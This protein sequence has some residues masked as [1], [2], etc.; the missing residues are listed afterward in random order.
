MDIPGVNV[1]IVGLD[2]YQPNHVEEFDAGQGEP[3]G[4]EE[5]HA[6]RS[7][8]EKVDH[9]GDAV[10][11]P[12]ARRNAEQPW[13]EMELGE[14][15]KVFN[16]KIQNRLKKSTFHQREAERQ[17]QRAAE[18]R[19]QALRRMQELEAA[20]NQYQHAEQ[21]AAA[22][23]S[24]DEIDAQRREKALEL[25][26]LRRMDEFDADYDEKRMVTLDLEL[27]D[28]D[29]AYN[30]MKSA[31]K[32]E[33]K[34]TPR[35]AEAPPAHEEKN[36]AAQWID[37]NQ[38]YTKDKQF[39]AATDAR[40]K[41]LLDEGFNQEDPELYAELDKR[42]R[43]QKPYASPGEGP[44]RGHE[45]GDDTGGGKNGQRFDPNIDA[46]V[47]RRLK[48]NPNDPKDRAKYQ[49]LEVRPY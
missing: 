44:A 40:F 36:Q 14:D 8:F 18:E 10:E 22:Q 45:G 41:E 30:T 43:Q 34:P 5:F 1:R 25:N 20:L 21:S 17:A 27:R 26:R 2:G 4:E 48:M 3:D 12:A 23:K 6:G 15:D 16:Q 29:H 46:A 19:D 47:M 49:Q 28:L 38:R 32:P 9:G 7:E 37:R 11:Q 31:P 13:R 42:L 35:Q 39:Q 33:A 24:L